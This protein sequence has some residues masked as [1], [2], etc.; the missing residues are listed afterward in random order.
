MTKIEE[1]AIR[2]IKEQELVMG[3]IAWTEARRVDGL[4]IAT[5]T[6]SEVAIDSS[7]PKTT[8]NG[9][10]ARYENLFGRAARETCREAV[11]SIIAELSPAEVPSSLLAA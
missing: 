7:D 1:I 10:V 2:I 3:P 9:L 5:G 11:A 8:I 4:R 6:P